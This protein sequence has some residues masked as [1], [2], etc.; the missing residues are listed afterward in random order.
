[1][2][3]HDL[4]AP[5]R[6]TERPMAVLFITN[7]F[8]SEIDPAKGIFNLHLARAMARSC[9]VHVVAPVAWSDEAMARLG[10]APPFS[11]RQRLEKGGVEVHHPRFLYPPRVLR[12]HYAWFFWRSI[13]STVGRIVASTQIDAVL[14]YWAH[15]DGEAAVRVARRAGVPGSR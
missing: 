7:V 12:E 4:D 13:R 5:A 11:R 2:A 10:G 14:G 9:K 15:P 3:T 6:E 8:P 1:M